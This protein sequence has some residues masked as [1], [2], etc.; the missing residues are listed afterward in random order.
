MDLS[1]V[2]PPQIKIK[3]ESIDSLKSWGT[4]HE[5]QWLHEML[6]P[7]KGKERN[8]DLMRIKRH[9]D[10]RKTDEEWLV[11]YIRGV[12]QRTWDDTA[13]PKDIKIECIWLLQTLQEEKEFTYET[14]NESP[15]LALQR[16]RQVQNRVLA[17][18]KNAKKWTLDDLKEG[19]C[20]SVE[21]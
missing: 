10:P 19:N 11:D 2:D 13:S 18:R 20:N 6:L 21:N 14:I 7:L 3:G 4:Q 16:S 12:D 15:F 5:I 17:D 9:I 8:I 1:P